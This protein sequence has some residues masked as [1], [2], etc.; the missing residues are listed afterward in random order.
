MFRILAFAAALAIAP[1]AHAH[2]YKLGTL[3]IGHP[4]SR[5]AAKGMT[6]VGYLSVSNKG[7]AA[8][9]LVA[10][11]TDA[12]ERVEIH[13]TSTAMGVMRMKKLEA[14]IAIAPGQTVKLEPGG[15][16]VMLIRLK[17]PLVAGDKVPATL[18]FKK[19]GRVSVDLA[20]QAG[21]P[22]PAGDPHAGH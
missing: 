14:G 11:E 21:G 12:A 15:K 17:R 6:G 1:A 3:E 22:K 20:V 8:D 10:V 7:A 9:T 5:P 18:V 19:A 2:S 4:W 16:H 13:E